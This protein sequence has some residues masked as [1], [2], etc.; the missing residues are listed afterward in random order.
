MAGRL[1]ERAAQAGMELVPRFTDG[2]ARARVRVSPSAV[3]QVLFNLVDNACKY[4]AP[5]ADRRIHLDVGLD[6]GRTSITVRDHGP[7]IPQPDVWRVFQPFRKSARA[8]A[9]S[10]PGVGLGLALSRRL[11]VDMGGRLVLAD[12]D[13]G[14]CFVLTLPLVTDATT[15]Q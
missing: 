10:A 8:A 9:N 14:A 13:G 15:G 6:S 2:A 7:G 4:A 5:A 3:E 12:S 11:A 1:S